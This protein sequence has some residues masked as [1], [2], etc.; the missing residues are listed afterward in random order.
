MYKV[1]GRKIWVYSDAFF[2]SGFAQYTPH[3]SLMTMLSRI[4]V[5]TVFMLAY[6]GPMDP[7]SMA[8][9]Y[10]GRMDPSSMPPPVS[11]WLNSTPVNGNVQYLWAVPLEKIH[12]FP[13]G[14]A[15]LNP[16]LPDW[17]RHDLN[18]VA[19]ELYMKFLGEADLT[20]R[21][22]RDA[23]ATVS[24]FRHFQRDLHNASDYVSF[25]A[26][27][28]ETVRRAIVSLGGFQRLLG[29]IATDFVS[30]MGFSGGTKFLYQARLR[31]E[32]LAPGDTVAPRSGA[33]EGAV[34]SGVVFTHIPPGT[35]GTPVMEV[36]DPR[37][38][39][40]PF[41]KDEKIP[42]QVGL[43]LMFPSWVNR[44]TPPHRWRRDE[45][46]PAVVEDDGDGEV[47][48]ELMK[49][50]RIDWVFE[51]GLFQYSHDVLVNFVD[52]ENCPFQNGYRQMEAQSFF[53]LEVEELVKL[54]MPLSP[55]PPP[56]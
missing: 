40:P 20:Q 43:G 25:L 8:P 35:R 41:G 34:A 31:A 37:G 56:Q 52:L 36:L 46:Q 42:A 14:Q 26:P 45:V 50:H 24:L 38:H 30:R 4:I 27:E 39:N 22:P 32:V 55:P 33:S 2:L 53:N 44:M 17:M 9:P 51:I 47:T 1:V 23:E 29:K 49:S 54:K 10:G 12:L 11:P 48:Y 15:G 7:S 6:G 13:N 18:I 3:P 16:L 5:L 21:D 19:M 28:T